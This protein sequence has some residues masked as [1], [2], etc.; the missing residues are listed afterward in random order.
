MGNQTYKRFCVSKTNIS[1][2]LNTYSDTSP[3]NNPSLSNFKWSRSINGISASE[4][5]SESI[6]LAP[7]ES[8]TLF[9]GTRTLSHDN[10][11]VYN[12]TLKSLSSNTYILKYVSGTLP[13]FR[14]PRNIATDATSQ[15]TITKNGPITT[16]TASG[17]TLF[18]TTAIQ[19][20][21]FVRIGS[22]FN[23]LNQG[24]FKIIAKTSTSFT[25]DYSGS[26]A[27]GPIT[28]GA[29]F[30]DQIQAYSALGVQ[31]NDTLVITG[32]FSLVT[33][34]SYN[35]TS[36][37]AQFV[38][39]YSTNILPQETSIQTN[40]FNVY[41]SS[42]NFLYLETD[43]KLALTINGSSISNI[44]PFIIGNSSQPGLFMLKS[45]IYSASI[46]NSGTDTANVFCAS[47]E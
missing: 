5:I 6:S 26:V 29:S 23:S 39:F 30:A 7:A 16:F 22:Q 17:G 33:Q 11:T 36:V 38:E 47:I 8:K 31:A 20:G 24:E 19:V 2:I 28:L 25:I 45:T 40:L 27:E 10:T 13:N 1:V 32:G 18:S 44:E 37:G 46:T 35:I 15:I 14:T 4:P 21:D 12:L 41:S 34:G 3:S 43:Q 42:K 9:D